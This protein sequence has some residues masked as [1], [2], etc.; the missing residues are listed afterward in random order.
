MQLQGDGEIAK[1]LDN[2][3]LLI[4]AVKLGNEDLVKEMLNAGVPCYITDQV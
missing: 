4:Q 2:G 3:K 1:L